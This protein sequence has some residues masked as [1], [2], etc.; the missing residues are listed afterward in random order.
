[1]A[2]EWNSLA[3]G[4]TAALI[5]P[6]GQLYT[7]IV[8]LVQETTKAENSNIK[9]LDV[10]CGPGEP[11]LTVGR[12]MPNATVIGIDWAEKMIEIANS[13]IN[14]AHLTNV[15]CKVL[16]ICSGD[17]PATTLGQ[18]D[19]IISSLVVMYLPNPLHV[20]K[21]LKTL[22]KDDGALILVVWASES[23]VPFLHI[24]KSMV[25][26]LVTGTSA[27][28]IEQNSESQH[29]AENTPG[30]FY[31][32][33]SEKLVMH[34]TEFGYKKIMTRQVKLDMKFDNFEHYF[35]FVKD[36]PIVMQYKNAHNVLWNTVK[37]HAIFAK[38]QEPSPND[39]FSLPSVCFIVTARQ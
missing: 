36:Q 23:Q 19:I 35:S 24:I 37:Q 28:Q 4:Y 32:S 20:L 3:Q 29:P 11:S 14:A 8:K 16:D 1:M 7:E 38:S 26:Q 25:Q 27:E 22:L 17:G 12:L 30:S 33:N 5:S 39:S 15:Q 2:E 34:L 6:F 21:K 10:G 31:Y 13:R 18:F 9:I